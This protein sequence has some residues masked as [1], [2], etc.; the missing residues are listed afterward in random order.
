MAASVCSGRSAWT[1]QSDCRPELC[2]SEC[3]SVD[4]ERFA[5]L[6]ASSWDTT[7]ASA[8][9]ARALQLVMDAQGGACI[10][11]APDKDLQKLAPHAHVSDGGGM[12]QRLK[13]VHIS[14]AVFTNLFLEFAQ[15]TSTDRWPLDHRDGL[16]RGRPKDGVGVLLLPSGF[17]VKCAVRLE[18][19]PQA[20][21]AWSCMG[22]R[23]NAALAAVEVMERA[24]VFLRSE[25]GAV[26]LLVKGGSGLAAYSVSD[27]GDSFAGNHFADDGD[28]ASQGDVSASSSSG[29]RGEGAR[30]AE[31]DFID[32]EQE[33]GKLVMARQAL[34]EK[35]ARLLID[36]GSGFDLEVAAVLHD[37]GVLCRE[38]GDVITARQHVE[39]SLRIRRKLL[40]ASPC[41]EVAAGLH[42]LGQVFREMRHLRMA[43][44][45]LQQS[46]EMKQCVSGGE[47]TS[48]DIAATL[49]ELGAVCVER[50][51]LHAAKEHLERVLRA[52]DLR[53]GGS[54]SPDRAR[55]LR[56]LGVLEMKSGNFHSSWVHLQQALCIERSIH[57]TTPHPDVARTLY[58][59][60]LVV[61]RSGDHSA[62]HQHLE[63]S[64]RISR[65]IHG[66]T[67]HRDVQKVMRL[68]A[69]LNVREGDFTS[70]RSYS[71]KCVDMHKAIYHTNRL[72]T[73]PAKLD[74]IGLF[75]VERALSVKSHCASIDH[76]VSSASSSLRSR[77]RV[78]SASLPVKREVSSELNP[79]GSGPCDMPH[80]PMSPEALG[81]G[82]SNPGSSKR[83]G[84]VLSR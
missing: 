75:V 24:I 76:L 31:C 57:G 36:R 20:S 9:A 37:L 68:L 30:A 8:V 47:T 12:T 19:L 56:E 22:M 5:S 33:A 60:G 38:G 63:E 44:R 82:G 21:K 72:S 15:H 11:L 52:E 41:P 48:G 70:W 39:E 16:L 83:R 69:A 71:R 35:L 46:L 1:M 59:L 6:A 62:A 29:D 7:C 23:H 64:L 14:S 80:R 28:E 84:G 4:A 79:C 27:P 61:L 55:A 34:E 78:G 45:C 17:R 2:V 77:F 50:R 43:Q 3:S 67:P 73:L 51:R 13:N 10:I 53:E 26:H 81:V 58:S 66:D 18:G 49:R 54:D 42:E 40:G 65:A 25:S 32:F 74:M